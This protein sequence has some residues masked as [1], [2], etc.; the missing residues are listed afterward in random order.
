[1]GSDD[2]E[3]RKK[4]SLYLHPEEQPDSMAFS[5]IDTVPRK[6]R[7]ELY[8]HALI[9]G[10]AL[11]QL[12]ERLPALLTALFTKSLTP[13][14]VIRLMADVTGWKP[15]QAEIQDVLAALN[16]QNSVAVPVPKPDDSAKL[17]VAR[18]KLKSLL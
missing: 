13:D 4:L 12:D 6:K 1:M 8:R 17:D 5:Q 18:T 2:I 7:G 9:S 15:S 16:L 10:L 11:H 3:G 14:M